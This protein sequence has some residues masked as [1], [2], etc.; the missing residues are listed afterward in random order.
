MWL[1][2]GE[3]LLR[4]HRIWKFVTVSNT[5]IQFV[6]NIQDKEIKTPLKN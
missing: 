5:P 1:I 2:C 6:K 4:G 3:G